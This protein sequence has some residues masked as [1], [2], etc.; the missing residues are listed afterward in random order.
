MHLPCQAIVSDPMMQGLRVVPGDVTYMVAS[1]QG[2]IL[3]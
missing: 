3:A 1:L 2:L